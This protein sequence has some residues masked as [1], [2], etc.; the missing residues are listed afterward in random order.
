MTRDDPEGFVSQL[1][2]LVSEPGDPCRPRRVDLAQADESAAREW[3]GPMQLP[4]RDE[5][6]YNARLLESMRG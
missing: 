4:E 1:A 2:G 3:G 5:C 6:P